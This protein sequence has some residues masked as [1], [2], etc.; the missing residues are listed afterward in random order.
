MEV[1]RHDRKPRG[2]KSHRLQCLTTSAGIASLAALP[3]SCQQ[4]ADF[5]RRESA[6]ETAMR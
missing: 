5:S 6:G 4:F 2:F 1:D 3:H